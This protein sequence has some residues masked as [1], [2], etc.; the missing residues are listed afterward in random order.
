MRA[1]GDLSAD[2]ED[3]KTAEEWYGRAAMLNDTPSMNRIA[4]LLEGRGQTER[5]AEWLRRAARFGDEE[6][7]RR[8]QGDV[9]AASV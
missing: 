4:T 6:A 1:L 9:V 2:R 8:L 5:A 7:A 3:L